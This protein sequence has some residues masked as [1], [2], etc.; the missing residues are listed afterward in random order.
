MFVFLSKLLPLFVYPLGLA[1]ALLGVALVIRSPRRRWL[2]P[3]AL[4]LLW[5]GGNRWVSSVLVRSLEWRYLPTAP[6]PSTQAIVLLGGG[7]RPQALP[8]PLAEVNEAGDRLFYAAWLYRQGKAPLVL[9]TGGGIEWRGPRL[10]ETEAM[11]DL[12]VFM[13]VPAEAILLESEAR[14]TYENALYTRQILAARGIDRILLVTSALHMPRAVR[15]FERQGFTVIPAPADFL[16]SQ[17]DW[18]SL[19]YPDPRQQVIQL[20]PDAEALYYTTL[21]LKE[22]IGMVIYGLRGW[23]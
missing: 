18:A 22:Y 11:R 7:T 17:A 12:L 9:V 3:A 5:L 13:G 16:V 23:L 6:L 10:P 8:R 14:N 1:C 2:I 20:F 4:V 19:T 15:L 21:A